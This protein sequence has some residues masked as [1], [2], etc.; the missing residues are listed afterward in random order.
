MVAP[1]I[2][3]P[4]YS[5]LAA[6]GQDWL[7]PGLEHVPADSVAALASNQAFVEAFLVGMNHEMS[8]ELLWRGYPTDQRGTVFRHF[9]D[10]RAAPTPPPGDLEPIHTWAR[11]SELGSHPSR[12][13]AAADRFVLL[14]RGELLRRFP[15]ATILL[16]PATLQGATPRPGPV[17]AAARLPV[18]SG[19]LD[20]DVTFLGFDVPPDQVRGDDPPT[21][22]RP[23]WFVVF[24][25]QPTE[26]RLGVSAESGKVGSDGRYGS[27]ADLGAADLATVGGATV[28]D[29]PIGYLDLAATT[30]QAFLDK[31][32][33]AAGEPPWDGRSETLAAIFLRR[34]F[35][36]F[37]HGSDLLVAVT[38]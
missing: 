7:L 15:R 12:A 37:L 14:L 29:R 32:P 27:W 30:T 4:M 9:W 36:L 8:R 11:Q 18:F 5:A 24:Q 19:R 1:Q 22:A 28:D 26:P 16:V 31:A 20:P 10:A 23:G 2:Q 6:L 35:R 3:A 21:T 17:D 38:P 13:S 34:P 33:Q 25:E